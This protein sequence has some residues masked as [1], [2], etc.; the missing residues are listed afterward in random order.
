MRPRLALV[1]FALFSTQADADAPRAPLPQNQTNA[2]LVP[3]PVQNMPRGFL[4]D[5]EKDRRTKAAVLEQLSRNPPILTLSQRAAADVAYLTKQIADSP[6]DAAL[7]NRRC[8]MRG[9]T[10]RDFDAALAD[11]DRS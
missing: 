3:A 4:F 2:G 1:I 8:F 9:L 11:C 6:D 7:Y 10:H 5:I